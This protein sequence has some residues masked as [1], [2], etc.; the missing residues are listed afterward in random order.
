MAWLKLDSLTALNDLIAASYRNTQFIFKHSNRCSIS[1]MAM[2][3]LE[4]SSKNHNIYILDVINHRDIS[5]EVE[6]ELSVV[7]QSPQL[8]VIGTGE[9]IHNVSHMGVSSSIIDQFIS[10][11]SD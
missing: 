8:L 9:C 7:H 5:N 10:N 1:A 6:R 4:K 3:R 2:H 11:S